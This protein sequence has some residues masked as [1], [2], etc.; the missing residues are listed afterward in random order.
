MPSDRLSIPS[1]S[2]APLVSKP[3]QRIPNVA[4]G[5]MLS[6]DM[7][8]ERLDWLPDALPFNDPT[9]GPVT[10]AV[11]LSDEKPVQVPDVS[12]ALAS[13]LYW[14]GGAGTGVG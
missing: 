2:S 6:P 12:V 8:L 7:V 3:C 1:P 13:A 9:V 5:A 4:P 11:K 10:G 14:K